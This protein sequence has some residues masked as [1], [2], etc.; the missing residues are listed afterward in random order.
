MALKIAVIG[1]GR[2]AELGHLPG[3]AQ[4]GAQVVAL[5]AQSNPNLKAMAER[6][7]VERCYYD[8]RALLA[9]GGFDAVSICTPTPQ[10][11]ELVMRCLERNVHVMV[12][13]PFTETLEQ[14]QALRAAAEA[15]SKL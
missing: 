5:C 13:K 12:E 2:I 14:A 9:D 6:F 3:F 8:W 10:H 11:Y 15:Q 7:R 1:A 4:S